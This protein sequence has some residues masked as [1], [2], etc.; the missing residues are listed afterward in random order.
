MTYK[1]EAIQAKHDDAI[2]QI[3]KAVGLEYGAVGEGFG[4]GDAEVNQMSQ[5]YTEDTKSLYLVAT[6]DSEVVGGGG[7]AELSGLADTCELKKL[8]L[9]PE[10][11]GLGLGKALAIQC[12]EFAKKQGYK[13]CYLD[14]LKTM[15]TARSLYEKLGFTY[16]DKPMGGSIHNGC[17]I[18]ML[19]SL[20][21]D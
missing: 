15:R 16:L 20:I 5:H 18:W 10:T 3:I 21:D 19:K 14:T 1:I 17:D 12:L 7:I 4:P 6:I 9:L 13:Q 8:F 11:R 2:A